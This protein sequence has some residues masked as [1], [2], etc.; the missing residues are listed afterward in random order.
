MDGIAPQRLEGYERVDLEAQSAKPWTVWRRCLCGDD[1]K[2]LRMWRAGV[3]RSFS[4]RHRN[5][6][7]AATRPHCGVISSMRHLWAECPQYDS[8]RVRI[9]MEHDVPA[10]CWTQ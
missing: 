7:E 2:N 6:E 4:R 8:A 3:A 1:D 9:A 5:D 10:A